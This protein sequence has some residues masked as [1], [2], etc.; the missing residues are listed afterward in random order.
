MKPLIVEEGASAEFEEAAERYEA[1]DVKVAWRF[2]QEVL[3]AIDAVHRSPGEWPLAPTVH[4]RFGVRRRL[5][6]GFP[7]AVVYKETEDAVWIIAVAHGKRRPGYW[8]ERMR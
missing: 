6:P 5:V 4:E 7:Y 1:E 8:R 2:V 3:A